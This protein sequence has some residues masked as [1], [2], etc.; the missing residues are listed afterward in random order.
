LVER[1]RVEH[2][3]GTSLGEIVRRLNADRL[4]TAQGGRQWWPSTV[5]GVLARPS[6]PKAEGV[7]HIGT[8]L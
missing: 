4:R 8:T 1:I 6:P 3:S 5:R 7:D 2:A